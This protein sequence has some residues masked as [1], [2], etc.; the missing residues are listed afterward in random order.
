MILLVGG[1]GSLGRAVAGRL[2]ADGESVRVMTRSPARGGA[3]AKAGAELVSGDLLDASSLTRACQGVHQVV[4]AA[5]SMLGRGKNSSAAVDDRGQ[6]LLIDVARAAGVRHF[7]YTS[8]YDVGPVY[9]T[10]PFFRIKY[11][12]E[13]YLAASGLGYTILRPTAFMEVHAHQ[14]IGE[15][16]FQKGFVALVGKGDRPKNFVAVDDVAYFAVRALR[17]ASMSGQSVD[18]GGPENLT[19]MEVVK[20]YETLAGRRARVVHIPLGVLKAHRLIRPLHEGAAQLMQ[21][22][23]IAETT[24]QTFDAGPLA[25]RFGVELTRLEDWAARRVNRDLSAPASASERS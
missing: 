4:S 17:D 12:I 11:E 1:T 14:L 7:V 15:S 5:H 21:A 19:S 22:G 16:V 25:R 23:I 9:R 6:R 24:D 8:V 18:I 13:S 2:L 3:L 10:V 20:I